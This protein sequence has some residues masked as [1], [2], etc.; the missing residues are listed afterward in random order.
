[1]ETGFED[2]DFNVYPPHNA[3]TYPTKNNVFT[4]RYLKHAPATFVIVSDD[5]SPWAHRLRCYGI[6]K[7]VSD[8][9]AKAYFAPDDAGYKEA[10]GQALAGA[11]QAGC[12]AD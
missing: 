7:T 5:D 1:V 11:K 12:E 9:A 8:A 4:V 10:Y 3:T 2:D 6:G